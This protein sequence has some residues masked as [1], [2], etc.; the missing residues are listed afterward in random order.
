MGLQKDC[1]ITEEHIFSEKSI[2]KPGVSH[3]NH[4]LILLLPF[5]NF[6]TRTYYL[7]H[8]L[9]NETWEYAIIYIKISCIQWIFVSKDII[10]LYPKRHKNINKK[11]FVDSDYIF[12]G[13]IKKKK[14]LA[15]AQG[16]VQA[17]NRSSKC[18]FARKLNFIARHSLL[19]SPPHVRQVMHYPS[20][21]FRG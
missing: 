18:K 3:K 20:P 6:V 16:L 5:V 13:L 2:I 1:S 10:L 12:C 9:W 14:K 8:M 7:L 21:R 15:G 17:W 11:S 19:L 4:D